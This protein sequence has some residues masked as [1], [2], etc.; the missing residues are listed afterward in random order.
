MDG[1]PD[2]TTSAWIA[3]E[4]DALIRDWFA[5]VVEQGCG[6]AGISPQVLDSRLN[7]GRF[8]SW[9]DDALFQIQGMARDFN[10]M[11]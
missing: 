5:E 4:R 11:L 1:R 8:S 7:F 2:S 10:A 9:Q 6:N 3:I